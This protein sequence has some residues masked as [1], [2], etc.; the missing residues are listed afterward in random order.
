M[1]KL[2]IVANWKS[3]KTDLETNLWFERFKI[4]DLGF[5][6]KEV[7]ICPS[8]TQLPFLKSYVLKPDLIGIN[9]KSSFKIGAQDI[10]PFGNGAHTGEVN[11]EQIKEFADY[12]LIGHSERQ[13]YF[14]ENKALLNDK[15]KMAKGA[16]LE[17]I[18]FLQNKDMLVPEGVSFAVYEPP[19]SIS[20]GIPD[21]P[22]NANNAAIFIKEKNKIKYVF[23][24]G[25][26]TS[27]NVKSFTEMSDIDGVLVGR[28]SLDAKEFG[29]IIKNA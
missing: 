1:K 26:V 19:N 18:F 20:P 3:N 7:I 2:F 28:A 25:N 21:T 27:E 23:Y 5:T 8:F 4:Y 11:G 15:I 12:V 6:N 16:N 10:S 24:G 29:E 17:P 14:F 13:K 9:H 22:E